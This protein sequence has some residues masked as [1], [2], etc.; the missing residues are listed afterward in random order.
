MEHDNDK[1]IDDDVR[2]NGGGDGCMV[3]D[4]HITLKYS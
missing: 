3:G 1:E 4:S 2:L